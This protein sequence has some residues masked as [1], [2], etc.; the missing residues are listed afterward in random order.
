[1]IF[2]FVNARGASADGKLPGARRVPRADLPGHRRLHGGD[3]H[4]AHRLAYLSGKLPIMPL[5]SGVVVLFFGA[6][7]LWLAG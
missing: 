1:V 2:F 7:T 6:L 3:H 4:L 5:V